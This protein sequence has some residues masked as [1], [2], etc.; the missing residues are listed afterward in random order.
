MKL[1]PAL[2]L[3][4]LLSACSF[5]LDALPTV[6]PNVTQAYETIAAEIQTRQPAATKASAAG[7]SPEPTQTTAVTPSAVP[8]TP[9]PP[10]NRIQA[11]IPFDITI[12]DNAQ[13]APGEV[14]VKTWRLV[15]TGSCAWTKAYSLAWFSGESLSVEH[16]FPLEREIQPGQSIDL[17]VELTAPTSPG[18]YQSNWVLM[19][20]DGKAFGIGP[21][22]NAAFWVRITVPAFTQPA[23][24]P[25]NT[26]LLSPGILSSGT[27][28]LQDGA[29]LQLANLSIGLPD[30]ADLTYQQ[31]RILP[32][33]H[34]EFSTS[35][36]GMPEYT[37]CLA[38]GKTEAPIPVTPENKYRYFCFTDFD[39]RT[40]WMQILGEG[41]LAV[42]LEILTWEK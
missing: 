38:I 33:N 5:P 39:G 25:T 11:G 28:Q 9:A 22:G 15:N 13:L 17:S 16:R 14:F 8:A 4:F 1:I 34:A 20:P 23:A 18:I 40:G 41:D 27:I 32:A 35:L 21:A 10:C 12:P 42:D 31:G 24:T 26:Y 19:D 29:G 2:P 37:T 7:K 6:T 36:G 3:I 30:G